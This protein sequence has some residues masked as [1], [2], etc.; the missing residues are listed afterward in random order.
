MRTYQPWVRQ[1]V[2]AWLLG[3]LNR[4]LNRVVL[5]Q[6]TPVVE[7]QPVVET[8]LR[9]GEV[10]VPSDQPIIAYR[11]WRERNRQPWRITP[12]RAAQEPERDVLP[13]EAARMR[14]GAT[15]GP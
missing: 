4:A 3:R 7:T 11:R 10:L 13:I 1:P 2:L 5:R 8:R 9:M 6:D 15:S 14:R 12:P